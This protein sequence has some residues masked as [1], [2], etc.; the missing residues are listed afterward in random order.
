[1]QIEAN[2]P[3]NPKNGKKDQQYVYF[4][5]ELFKINQH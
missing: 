5:E 2:I 3:Y 4:D 1:M